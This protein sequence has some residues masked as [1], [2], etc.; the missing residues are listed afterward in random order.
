M[1]ALFAIAGPGIREGTTI[2]EVQNVD[3]YHLLAELLGLR[4]ARDTDGQP[5]RIRKM[6]MR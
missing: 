3:V 2:D 6:V 4:A 5:G 1:Q